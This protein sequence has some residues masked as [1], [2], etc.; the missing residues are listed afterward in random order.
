MNHDIE[1]EVAALR[2]MTT[3]QVCERYAQLFGEAP[4]KAQGIF[5]P[6]NRLANPGDRG[7]RSERTALG[8]EPRNWPM[9][10]KCE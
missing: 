10:P 2:Q 5:D 9:T 3:G 6:Q 8:G 7:R 1:K 4:N